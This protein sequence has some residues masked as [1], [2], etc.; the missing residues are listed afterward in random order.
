MATIRGTYTCV[1]GQAHVHMNEN[2][3][4]YL[5]MPFSIRAFSFP[6]VTTLEL[7]SHSTQTLVA[8]GNI[9]EETHLFMLHQQEMSVQYWSAFRSGSVI[10]FIKS[11]LMHAIEPTGKPIPISK[12]WAF[13]FEGSYWCGCGNAIWS[14]P[15][16][17][18]KGV[19]A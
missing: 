14:F 17:L 12:A 2:V 11:S 1:F 5:L 6:T 4:T 3:S 10:S 19:K 8:K 16:L 7:S 15:G 9:Y 13:W 18:M